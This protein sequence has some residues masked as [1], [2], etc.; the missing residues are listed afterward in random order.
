MNAVLHKKTFHHQTRHRVVIPRNDFGERVECLVFNER[1]IFIK[2]SK[3][4]C[5]ETVIERVTHLFAVWLGVYWQRFGDYLVI[6][7]QF[8]KVRAEVAVAEFSLNFRTCFHTRGNAREYGEIGDVIRSKLLYQNV[9]ALVDKRR[10]FFREGGEHLVTAGLALVQKKRN[11]PR[12]AAGDAV[13]GEQI[14]GGAIRV[15]IRKYLP[16]NIRRKRLE[17]HLLVGASEKRLLI[18]KKNLFHQ[19]KHRTA[20]YQV[21]TTITFV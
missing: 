21:D 20:D 12:H 8:H 15:E 5:Q 10:I 14:F 7:L 18:K 2:K 6:I 1:L 16:Q 3:P 9:F 4:K 13:Q 19:R 17:R 11:I